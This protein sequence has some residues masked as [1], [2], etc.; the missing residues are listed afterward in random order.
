MSP[1]AAAAV[2]DLFPDVEGAVRAWLRTVNLGPASGLVYFGVPKQPKFPL[3]VLRRAG[4]GPQAGYSPVDDARISFDCWAD[5]KSAASLVARRLLSNIDQLSMVAV[6]A[7]HAV[8]L[9]GVILLG[10]L[11]RPDTEARTA[12]GLPRPRYIVDAQITVRPLTAAGG[13]D[14]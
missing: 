13:A 7:H 4:G 2:V 3:V 6:A 1:A 10:P 5:T 8:L 11:W 9:G 12:Q 14:T